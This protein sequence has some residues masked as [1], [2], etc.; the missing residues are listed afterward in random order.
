M[1]GKTLILKRG[2]RLWRARKDN[3]VRH[4][5]ALF[6]LCLAWLGA[7]GGVLLVPAPSAAQDD[8]RS[9]EKAFDEKM[10]SRMKTVLESAPEEGF[11]LDRLLE[12]YR[13]FKSVD[14]LIAE[15]EEK[16]A[17]EPSRASLQLIIG[18]LYKAE[19][20]N[21]KAKSYFEKARALDPK[22]TAALLAMAS[23]YEA[24]Q[25]TNQAISLYEEALSATTDKILKRKLL[26][27][28]VDLYI[29]AKNIPKAKEHAKTLAKTDPKNLYLA[30]EFPLALSKA[31]LY[32]EA[33]KEFTSLLASAN[34]GKAKVTILKEL[35]AAYE[36][37][38]DDKQAIASYE[39][40]L[41][42][43]LKGNSARA[44]LRERIVAV[45]RKNDEVRV[46]ID[47]LEKEGGKGFEEWE[48][49]GRLYEEVAENQKAAAAL[50]K[51]I[52]LSPKRLEVRERLIRIYER[53]N[54]FDEVIKQYRA[55]I[56]AAPNDARWPIALASLLEQ[57]KELPEALKILAEM[58]R[59]HASDPSVRTALAELYSRFGQKEEALKE[60]EALVKLEPKVE[61]H[62][63]DLG[64][65][66]WQLDRQSEAKSTWKK[67][68]T[69][70]PEGDR[71]YKEYA[72]VLGQHDLFD[73]AIS[74]WRK[75][76]EKNPKE[77]SYK[78]E[79]AMLLERA[80]RSVEAIS[81]WKEI[82][83]E[84]SLTRALR[85]ESLEHLVSLYKARDELTRE[86][87]LAK[88][89]FEKDPTDLLNG[90]F[91][92]LA[93]LQL[94]KE[95]EAI[96]VLKILAKNDPQNP[97]PLHDLEAIY[98]RTRAF[99]EAIAV[100]EKLAEL[101]PQRAKEYYLKISEYLTSLRQDEEA[102]VFMEKALTLGP[103]DAAGYAKRGE[104]FRK[105]SKHKEAIEAYEKAIS[106]NRRAFSHYFTLA[107]L[108]ESHGRAKD[109]EALYREVLS[110]SPNTSEV[111]QAADA[112]IR[113]ALEQNTLESLEKDLLALF[114]TPPPRPVYQRIL[115]DFYKTLAAEPI[116]SLNSPRPEKRKA[117]RE[118]L[119]EIGKRAL[120][121]LLQALTDGDGDRKRE[122]AR[123][124]GYLGNPNGVLPLSAL[125]E[126]PDPAYRVLAAISLGRIGDKSGVSALG[127]V[128]GSGFGE[129]MVR[130]AAA[131]ALGE[132]KSPNAVTYLAKKKGQGLDDGVERVRVVSALSLAN[133]GDLSVVPELLAHLDDQKE[134]SAD[135]R[136]AAAYALG[137]L[138]AKEALQPLQER[139]LADPNPNVKRAAALALGMIGDEAAVDSLFLALWEPNRTVSSRVASALMGFG[140]PVAL[141]ER[142]D[143]SLLFFKGDGRTLEAALDL[144]RHLDTLLR[145]T[146]QKKDA[147]A[148][149][150]RHK[151][152]LKESILTSL[153]SEMRR[154]QVLLYL[155]EG[156][157]R[158]GLGSLLSVE[159]EHKEEVQALLQEIIESASPLLLKLL[160]EPDPEIQQYT[161]SILGKARV[162]EAVAPLAALLEDPGLSVYLYRPVAQALGR[163]GSPEALAALRKAASSG[164][165]Y[166]LRLA[167]AEGFGVTKDPAREA[168]LLP[169]LE[170]PALLVREVAFEALAKIGGG[171]SLSY[172]ASEAAAKGKVDLL[173]LRVAQALA[174]S[175]DPRAE[176]L[177]RL[178]AADPV[179]SVARA[180]Q[181]SL[182]LR[183]K[184]Q[185]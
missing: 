121:P 2:N 12:M 141:P 168:D 181:K 135:V 91:L 150:L 146:M 56:K 129:S 123:L 99:E 139:L 27:T 22:S 171:S 9:Q 58:R 47:L 111:Q 115:V 38:G 124:V 177:L 144:D 52:S 105:Q 3:Y 18:F 61:S 25:E 82:L 155:D 5:S 44:E 164:D 176:D 45:Y 67:L 69:V 6:V 74:A 46:Y 42:M 134:S 110:R 39:K 173:R 31:E 102:L 182:E 133:Q 107:F 101:E 158:L 23:L 54:N 143:L 167:A 180:A 86:I 120:F 178:L 160:N 89:A 77:I 149:I 184:K 108:Y 50:E 8:A 4:R 64:E 36:A 153:S 40:A 128:L 76:L 37:K 81:L 72:L 43:T 28:L 126:D 162:E 35:G 30:L 142:A 70:I 11:V 109:A 113:L 154:R 41:A 152:V 127:R 151:K 114:H 116:A 183:K 157:D 87:T 175:S 117:A 63:I 10:A 80:R 106:L 85:R 138:K 29:D 33:I 95:K 125:L 103:A 136:L 112:A 145:A 83:K 7:F 174:F 19:G 185:G 94:N 166:H 179:V 130:A 104:I 20:R 68:L 15:Y 147:T 32:E 140:E 118:A 51:A 165:L 24:T 90:A 14:E 170:D 88:M 84:P 119:D 21:E 62:L 132:I 53:V 131:W 96:A 13:T 93:Y 79:F 57:R 16:A 34:D 66:Y 55:L 60:Y 48:L 148:L 78:R 163:I 71:A 73:E 122:A 17:K 137:M 172:A 98:T 1:K 169:L 159:G 92:A 65:A 75:A 100:L 97:E 49:L 59:R 26:G 156:E 161:A